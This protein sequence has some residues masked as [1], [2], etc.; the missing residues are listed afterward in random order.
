MSWLLWCCRFRDLWDG[1]GASV[2]TR[3][4][5]TAG[6]CPS[7]DA[8]GA[9]SDLIPEA[10]QNGTGALLVEV[11]IYNPTSC[12]RLAVETCRCLLV[13]DGHRRFPGAGSPG[14]GSF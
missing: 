10:E 14:S 1:R 3:G 4:R 5:A 13:R 9:G 7:R 8:L 6:S 12:C 2:V 11:V